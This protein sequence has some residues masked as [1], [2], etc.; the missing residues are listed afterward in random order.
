[1]AKFMIRNTD[2]PLTTKDFLEKIR[3]FA[4]EV[5]ETWPGIPQRLRRRFFSEFM[6]VLGTWFQ[7]EHLESEGSSDAAVITTHMLEDVKIKADALYRLLEEI[8][9][10]ERVA[11]APR[12][13][14]L[15]IGQSCAAQIL[16]RAGRTATP[17][18]DIDSILVAL[19]SMIKAADNPMVEVGMVSYPNLSH[20][21]VLVELDKLIRV[22]ASDPPK[23]GQGRPAGFD[24]YR[25]L[26]YL[27]FELGVTFARAGVNL[28][29]YAKDGGGLK[30]AAG[31]LIQMLE[32][33]DECLLQHLDWHTH[34]PSPEDHLHHIATY[35]RLL[36]RARS[37]AA[38]R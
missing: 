16:Q 29:A 21:P 12:P 34:L 1:M 5:A 3:P 17:S 26:D 15:C 14:E 11:I 24:Q 37:H 7:K 36:A 6:N 33:L 8:V 4:K 27:V 13:W 19:S 10:P 32:M 18:W 31:S 25:K 38:Q 22:P 23:R 28:T 30:V 35:Q 20:K 9:Y 2:P